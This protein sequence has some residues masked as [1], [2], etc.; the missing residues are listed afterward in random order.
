MKGQEQLIDMRLHRRRP[1]CV[2]ID[3]EPFDTGCWRDWHLVDP[4]HAH[5]FI[6]ANERRLDLR[7]ITGLPCFI[8]GVDLDRVRVI[9]DQCIEAGASRVIATVV[10]RDVGDTWAVRRMSDTEGVFLA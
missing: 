9:R 2:W 7:L 5:L 3:L 6:P 4:Q 8:M 1:E 10:Q